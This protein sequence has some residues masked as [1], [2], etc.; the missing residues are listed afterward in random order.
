VVGNDLRFAGVE[1]ERTP[2]V[3]FI[4]WYMR[5][6]HRAAWNDASLSQVFLRVVNLVAPPPSL[7]H[8]A[9]VLRVLAGNLRGR[10]KGER[11]L[12]YR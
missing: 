9:V 12:I 3:R 10:R 5:H 7:L 8:P 2:M 4:N 1:G 11:T 6:F